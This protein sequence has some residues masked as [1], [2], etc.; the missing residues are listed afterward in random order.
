ML[1]RQL[2][3]FF[4]H[5]EVFFTNGTFG[6]T[7]CRDKAIRESGFDVYWMI[8]NDDEDEIFENLVNSYV[9]KYWIEK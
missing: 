3:D 4:T 8:I 6:R 2:L 7:C 9:R 5:R 1:A